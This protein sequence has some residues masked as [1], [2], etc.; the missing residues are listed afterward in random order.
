M[1]DLSATQ[2]AI[3]R[4]HP[5]TRISESDKHRHEL[6]SVLKTVSVDWA[7]QTV[8]KSREPARGLGGLQQ[9][10]GRFWV[11]VPPLRQVVH[12]CMM[13]TLWVLH[14]EISC[15]FVRRRRRAD[16]VPVR[17]GI[18]FFFLTRQVQVQSR[19]RHL[20]GNAMPLPRRRRARLHSS[21]SKRTRTAHEVR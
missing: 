6:E 13:M 15:H 19:G 16:S 11:Y 12:V 5:E 18:F 1:Y 2:R 7:I 4:T 17:V 8:G 3:K 14:M 9:C 10:S 20:F 21:Q